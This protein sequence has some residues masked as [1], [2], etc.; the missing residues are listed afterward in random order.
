MGNGKKGC[1]ASVFWKIFVPLVVIAI[2]LIAVVLILA[3][4]PAVTYPA[5]TFDKRDTGVMASVVTRL[6]RSLVDKEGRVVETAELHLSQNEVRILLNA[7]MRDDREDA[8]ETVPYAAMWEDGKLRVFF[9]AQFSSGKAANLFVELAPHV[10]E[11]QLTIVPG[12]G[13]VG[14]LPLPRFALDKAA[15]FLEK[16]AMSREKVR[17]AISPFSSIEPGENGSLVLMFDP[18]D[19]NAVVRV[20]RSAGGE[21]AE[22]EDD[23]EDDDEYDDDDNSEDIDAEDDPDE[24]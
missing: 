11:G 4:G 18:R 9:S 20:L 19:V 12:S 16:E 21:D 1:L 14:Q 24:E 13:S 8:P 10:D 22:D 2:V 3:T 5:P 17:T 15:R 7:M 6:A 23:E